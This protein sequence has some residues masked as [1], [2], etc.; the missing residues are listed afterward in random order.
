MGNEEQARTENAMDVM[1][2]PRDHHPDVPESNTTKGLDADNRRR[3]R[4]SKPV[5]QRRAAIVLVS[6]LGAICF[7]CVPLLVI[8]AKGGTMLPPPGVWM[9]T[10]EGWVKMNGGN[11][12]NINAKITGDGRTL[13]H[14]A[15][16]MGHVDIFGWLKKRGADV[17]A[18]DN[19]GWTPMHIAASRGYVEAMKRLKEQG[20]DI[21]TKGKYNE[22]FMHF[23]AMSGQVAV[24]KWLKEQGV[25]VNAKTENGRTP[26]DVGTAEAKAW[27]YANGA[28]L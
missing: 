19:N 11:L 5:S 24:M 20:A 9:R 25:D 28:T 2:T 13:M 16:A 12:N 14:L 8:D 10:P 15:A 17:N 1:A 26:F 23:A 4:R 22:T 27:L 3:Q 7:S 21:N 6:L 18:K